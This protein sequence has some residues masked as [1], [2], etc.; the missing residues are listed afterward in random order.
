M[1]N[2]CIITGSRAEYGLLKGIMN[3]IKEDKLFNLILFVTGS[4]LEEKYG[5]TYK[6]IEND[7]FTINEK[8]KMNLESDDPNGILQSMSIELSTLSECLSKYN[9]DL[10]ILLGDRYEILIASQVALIYNIPIAHLCGGDTTKGAYD[11]KIRNSISKLS[12]FHF[13]TSKMAYSKLI[14]LGENKKNIFIVGNPGLYDIINFNSMSSLNLYS[15]LSIKKKKYLILI[16]YHSETLLNRNQNIKNMNIFINSLLLIKNFKETNFVFISSNA[17]NFNS[18]IFDKIK[19]LTNKYNNIYNFVSLD[20]HMYLNII[21]HCNLFIGN[22]SS[23][24]YE[25]PL[26]KKFTLNIG[27]RQKGRETGNSVINL[28]YNQKRITYVIDDIIQIK[29]EI[30]HITYPYPVLNT[31]QIFVDILKNKI[32]Y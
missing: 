22:S 6:N 31:S 15:S 19:K 16:A 30:K 11:E 1:K 24:I 14:K 8:I 3:T 26:F 28:D 9:I 32:L 17:D 18:F 29:R 27:D 23:G 5:L 20:R 12:S 4:H 7:G 2:I 25:V 21:Y 13:V 10:F